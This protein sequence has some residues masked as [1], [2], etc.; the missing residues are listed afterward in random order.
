MRLVHGFDIELHPGWQ[1]AAHRQAPEFSHQAPN[2]VVHAA[3]VPLRKDEG[4]FGS[5]VAAR[6]GP[7]DLFCSFFEYD[8]ASVGTAL[9]SARGLPTPRPSDFAVGALQRSL[10]GQSGGQWFF[11]EAG[12][13]WCLFVILGAHSRRQAGAVRVGALL[14]GI[15]IA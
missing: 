12:R 15:R 3:T 14:K 7:D 6:L 8:A 5:G 1:V 11:T 2:L 4:D 9:F 10:P 13:A